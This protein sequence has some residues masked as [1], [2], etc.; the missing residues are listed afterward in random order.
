MTLILHL[1]F[2]LT[3]TKADAPQRVAFVDVD[4][5]EPGTV[6]IREETFTTWVYCA[7]SDWARIGDRWV[8]LSDHRDCEEAWKATQE[9]LDKR[10]RDHDTK[11]KWLIAGTTTA[12]VSIIVGLTFNNWR[13]DR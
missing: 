3:L 4:G 2:V 8:R 1:I 10:I 12:L 5:L 6:L 13:E 7:T 11:V 9:A